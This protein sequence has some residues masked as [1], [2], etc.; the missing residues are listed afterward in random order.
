MHKREKAESVAVSAASGWA[1]RLDLSFGGDGSSIGHRVPSSK[2]T[3][4]AV[5]LE[6][7]RVT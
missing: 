6:P 2:G 1:R 3:A 7:E 4:E 5:D